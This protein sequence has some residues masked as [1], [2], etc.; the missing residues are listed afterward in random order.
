MA[1]SFFDQCVFSIFFELCP[2]LVSCIAS[3]DAARGHRGL[4]YFSHEQ[5]LL[6]VLLGNVLRLNRKR[7]RKRNT[8]NVSSKTRGEKLLT[9]KKQ[10]EQQEQEQQQQQQQQQQRKIQTNHATS[11]TTLDSE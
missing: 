11:S 9:Q 10:Q 2:T 1:L 5:L 3:T 6:R 8:S 4:P 7:S